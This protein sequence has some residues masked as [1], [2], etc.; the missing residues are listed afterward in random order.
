M[1]ELEQQQHEWRDGN[2]ERLGNSIATARSIKGVSRLKLSE[3]TSALGVPIHRVAIAKI[4]NGE[5]DIT[6]TE[7]VALSVA[8]DSDWAD[9]LAKAVDRVPIEKLALLRIDQQIDAL[10]VSQIEKQEM[11]KSLRAQRKK[12]E[13]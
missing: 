4:E 9:W 12:L 6:V 13:A 1:D 5:R 3:A 10:R 8:L 11:I 7:L 2:L